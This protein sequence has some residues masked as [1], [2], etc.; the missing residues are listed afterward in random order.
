MLNDKYNEM[1]LKLTQAKNMEKRGNTEGA[2]KA[3]IGLIES[4]NL[5]DSFAYERCCTLL[6][7]KA[8]YTEAKRFANMCLEKIK[9]GE[10][11]ASPEFFIELL[12][13]AKERELP[14][15]VKVQSSASKL[16]FSISE[17]KFVI[18]II[19]V[20]LVLSIML[21]LPDKLFKLLFVFF[22]GVAV[23]FIIEVLRNL[24]KEYN[25]KPR[26]II[27]ILSILISTYGAF[28]M[29]K[30]EW[31]NFLA[32]T[33]LKNMV[34]S[35]TMDL[36]GQKSSDKQEEETKEEPKS[37]IGKEDIEK[38][39][40]VAEMHAELI[41][42]EL[43]IKGSKIKLKTVFSNTTSVDRA[44]SIS[45]SL[46]RDLNTI[47]GF[48]GSDGEKLG[49]IYKDYSCEINVFNEAGANIANADVNKLTTRLTWAIAK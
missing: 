49:G 26:I 44:K 4:Y 2:L 30:N 42:H 11:N 32:F 22:A 41:S 47:K 35:G 48:E 28:N 19:L 12:N 9:N 46:L 37:E 3:Y 18:S 8:R 29:P 6:M 27:I 45:E 20:V 31:Q 23:V 38:L 34:K 1:Y 10:I 39:G 25:I 17:N 24:Q 16:N 13:K 33:T 40:Q 7:Q 5:Q 36:S 15:R 14:E 21:S 43:T